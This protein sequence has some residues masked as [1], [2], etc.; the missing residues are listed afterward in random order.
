MSRLSKTSTPF[1]IAAILIPAALFFSAC[2]AK[3]VSR[4]DE[5]PTLDQ[6]LETGVRVMWVAAHPDDESGAGAVLAKAGRKCHDP[7]YFLVL[8][9]GDGGDCKIPEGC[10]P[11]L[12][13]VREGELKK[14]A[15]LY[16]ATLQH[17]RFWNAP[18]PVKSFPPRHEIA[19][20]W[21]ATADPALIVAK[22]IRSFKPD[23]VITLAPV[24]GASGHPEHQA[25]SRFASSGIRLAAEET[26][27]LE[28]TP[29]RVR[30]A[31]YILNSYWL[32]KLLGS[33]DPFDPTETFDARQ[34][35]GDGMRCIEM[36]AEFTKPHRSQAGDMGAMRLLAKFVKKTYL[37]RVDP[38]KEY[39][40]PYEP[41]T[42]GGMG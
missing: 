34:S 27:R 12:A 40:D 19:K 42:H 16:G 15:E 32:G 14:V 41:A 13:T 39:L 30:Y 2:A 20:K 36:M 9:H 21:A 4:P 10:F 38:F 26:D 18:L 1:A 5:A 7:L 31:Y 29:H 8:T 37:Y 6:L 35:C 11:D 22:A 25:A 23:V 33:Y 17:E 28:G 3:V 24:H